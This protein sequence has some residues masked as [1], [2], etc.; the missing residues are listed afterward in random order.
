M[1]KFLEDHLKIEGGEGT[2]FLETIVN[3]MLIIVGVSLIVLAMIF[4]K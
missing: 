2:P 3:I 4:G 1:S